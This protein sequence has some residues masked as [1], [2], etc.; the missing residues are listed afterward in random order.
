M[1][2]Y[3]LTIVI[4][5]LIVAYLIYRIRLASK[6]KV[7]LLITT[8]DKKRLWEVFDSMVETRAFIKL[9]SKGEWWSHSIIKTTKLIK[10]VV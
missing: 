2:L 10:K 9:N 3:A 4:L 6:E 1:P 7:I 5:A 8:V